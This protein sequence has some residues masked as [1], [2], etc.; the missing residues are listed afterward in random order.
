[1][2]TDPGAGQT[3]QKGSTV[4][5]FVSVG[6][7]TVA[8]P[9]LSGKSVDDAR[10]TL[11][12]AGLKLGAVFGPQGKNRKVFFQNPGAGANVNRGTAVSVYTQ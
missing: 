9:N 7:Q 4:T 3:A 11:E 6:P 2:R 8:V 10:A 1:V 12:A 5:I